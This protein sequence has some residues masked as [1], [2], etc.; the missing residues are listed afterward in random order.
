MLDEVR[1]AV[2]KTLQV[3]ACLDV[4]VTLDEVAAYFL[5]NL[6]MSAEE[7]RSLLV[8]KEF[9]DLPFKISDDYILTRPTQSVARRLRVE[10]V[11][12]AK[13]RSAFSLA[14]VLTKLVPFIRSLAVTGSVA[15]ASAEKWDDIDLFMITAR[16]RLWLSAFLTLV[17]VRLYKLL[18][19]RSQDLLRFCLCYAHDEEG[20]VNESLKN[21]GNQLFAR[22]LLKAKPIA[23]RTTYSRILRENSWAGRLYAAA[24]A[25]KLRELKGHT[26]NMD[27][28]CKSEDA[29]SVFLDWVDGLVFVFLGN[30][31]RVRAYL[32][33]LRLKS[34]GDDLR[35]FEPVISPSSCVYSSNLYRWL[36]SLWSS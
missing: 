1:N 4:P 34:L 21:R 8:E 6:N 29:H 14:E 33:N 35:V 32:S 23:G 27:V 26:E 9:A 13:L 18:H 7:L 22:E 12:A 5:P 30:Y 10:E 11:S 15:Y 2:E 20:F 17:L 19:L 25:L 36:G 28:V 31:L 24:Y 16:R 3:S